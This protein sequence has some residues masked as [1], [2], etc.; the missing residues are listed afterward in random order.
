[1]AV[2]IAVTTAHALRRLGVDAPAP[3][4]AVARALAPLD[5]FH[6]YGLF[7]V[8]TS[9]RPEIEV[10]G[11]RDGEGWRAYG[12]RWKP[13]R[14]DEPPRFAGVHM[15]RLDWQL[16]FAALEGSCRRAPWFLAFVERLLEAEPA[17]LGLLAD[18]PFEG[19]RP[20]AVRAT[21]FRYRF[22]DA[23]TRRRTGSWWTREELGPYCPPLELTVDGL[24]LA[25]R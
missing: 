4:R 6:A 7:A 19:E 22:A 18:D 25:D 8:M 14:T 11:S 2:V 5:S 9:D 23:E 1:V 21:L 20:A 24:G 15:P 10:E 3:L 17:V 16:W 12:F 13:D